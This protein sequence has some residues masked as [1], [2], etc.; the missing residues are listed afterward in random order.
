MTQVR[1]ATV[2]QLS[3]V[4]ASLALGLA[5]LLTR[6]AFAQPPTAQKPTIVLV[7]GAF[8]DASSWNAVVDRLQDQGFT[9][10]APANP[11]RGL[12]SDAPYISSVLSTISGPIV[13]VGHSYGGA[14]IT[15]A[16]TGN[17]NVKALVYVAAYIPDQGQTLAQLAP[18]SGGSELVPPG[19]PG[20]PPTL[21]VTP[22]PPASCPAGLEV[23]IV[24]GDFQQIFAEDLRPERTAIMAVEQRPLSVSALTDQSGPPAWKTIRSFALVANQDHAIGT[25]NEL[26]MAQHAGATTVRVDGSHVVM[27]SHP[28]AV[29]D[30][31]QTAVAATN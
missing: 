21:N 19:V 25:A 5:L 20:V 29:V 8:A 1:V 10:S 12:A 3:P 14:V 31:I 17:P 18:A 27:I 23:S 15:N 13:L 4:A 7:H 26:A 2:R 6:G 22:C 30:L 24:P 9:V 16:A 28:D 11:L